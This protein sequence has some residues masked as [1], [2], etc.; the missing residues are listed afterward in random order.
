ML[1]QGLLLRTSLAL[2]GNGRGGGHGHIAFSSHWK[3]KGWWSWPYRAFFS[4]ALL[5][6]WEREGYIARTH[7]ILGCSLLSSCHVV[8]CNFMVTQSLFLKSFKT[9]KTFRAEAQAQAWNQAWPGPRLRPKLGPKQKFY[10]VLKM[11][12]AWTEEDF[13]N[14]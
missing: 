9:F 12:S 3:G 5:Y 1:I 4:K 2:L 6:C 11:H 7:C 13:S 8:S 14:L 10:K